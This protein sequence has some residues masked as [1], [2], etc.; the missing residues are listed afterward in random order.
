MNTKTKEKTQ[1]R[2]ET[3]IQ[4]KKKKHDEI[5]DQNVRIQR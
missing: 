5:S 1:K 3:I 4:K 2:F